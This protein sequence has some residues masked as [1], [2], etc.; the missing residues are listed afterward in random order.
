MH[1]FRSI[2][3]R[4]SFGKSPNCKSRKVTSLHPAEILRCL[5]LKVWDVEAQRMVSLRQ[6]LAEPVATPT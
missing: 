3:C 5:R 4:R 1:A 6:V 2:G